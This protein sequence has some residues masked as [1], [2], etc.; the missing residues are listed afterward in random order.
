MAQKGKKPQKNPTH[1]RSSETRERRSEEEE[2]E[3]E[4]YKQTQAVISGQ[5]VERKSYRRRKT[6][7]LN[8]RKKEDFGFEERVQRKLREEDE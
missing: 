8:D 5:K 3:C 4:K 6:I 1:T 7:P 2:L